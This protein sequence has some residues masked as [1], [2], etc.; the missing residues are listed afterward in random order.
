MNEPRDIAGYDNI[1]FSYLKKRDLVAFKQGILILAHIKSFGFLLYYN[2][3]GYI[4]FRV[5]GFWLS[6]VIHP[7]IV[8]VIQ[9]MFKC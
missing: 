9:H 5:K 7:D 2:I 1:F 4:F 6:T 3:F 8:L